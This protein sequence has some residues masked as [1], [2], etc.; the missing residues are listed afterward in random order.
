MKL[1]SLYASQ[2]QSP[3]SLAK[4]FLNVKHLPGACKKYLSSI[5]ENVSCIRHFS[6]GKM[7]CKNGHFRV[8][9][10]AKS[11]TIFDSSNRSIMSTQWENKEV[12]RMSNYCSDHQL[13]NS[14]RHSFCIKE[15][16]LKSASEATL[17][18][19]SILSRSVP[20]F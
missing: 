2:E 12:V 11:F 8:L 19:A 17:S 3:H 10:P 20:S 14:F 7:F 6:S 15:F 13:I 4:S 5:F 9:Y 1:I 18:Y 16:Y